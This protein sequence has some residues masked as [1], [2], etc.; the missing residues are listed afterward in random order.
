MPISGVTSGARFEIAGRRVADPRRRRWRR[1]QHGDARLLTETFGITLVRGRGFTERDRAGSRPVAIVNQAFV[2]RY[3]PGVEPIGQRLLFAPLI[4][5]CHDAVGCAGMGDRRRARRCRQCGPGSR[6]LP[7]SRSSVLAEPV[8]ARRRGGAAPS[9]RPAAVQSGN[10]RRHSADRS[11]AADGQRARRSSR[12]LSLSVAPTASTRC[13][14]QLLR[15]WRCC[16]L[17]SA[18]TA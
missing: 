9:A 4:V 15:R 7:R 14:L 17:P 1:H 12:R 18:S 8:A 5:G 2:K 16:W 11:R 3:L 6:T 13:S 10:R